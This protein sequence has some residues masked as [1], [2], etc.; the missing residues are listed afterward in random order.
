[1]TYP[2][3]FD[4]PVLFPNSLEQTQYLAPFQRI[5]IRGKGNYTVIGFSKKGV[6]VLGDNAKMFEH[7]NF[8]TFTNFNSPDLHDNFVNPLLEELLLKY[9]SIKRFKEDIFDEK[10]FLCYFPPY[11]LPYLKNDEDNSTVNYLKK[12][13]ELAAI[14]FNP[15]PS[16]IELFTW[17]EKLYFDDK[18]TTNPANLP[19]IEKLY[20]NIR[21]LD[22][23]LYQ[24]A[25]LRRLQISFAKQTDLSFADYEQL[26]V[27]KNKIFSSL[28][29]K[30]KEHEGNLINPELYST[31][32]DSETLNNSNKHALAS[33]LW[34]RRAQEADSSLINNVIDY[35]VTSYYVAEP[36][37]V[38]DYFDQISKYLPADS[39][40]L[41]QLIVIEN[42]AINIAERWFQAN[43][44]EQA[45]KWYTH[46]IANKQDLINNGA[47]ISL[48]TIAKHDAYLNPAN[49]KRINQIRAFLL[50]NYL[51]EG[52]NF[53][54]I[55]KMF[56]SIKP[57]LLEGKGKEQFKTNEK[58]YYQQSIRSI[59]ENIDT[60]IR[61]IDASLA[62]LVDSEKVE[63]K[64]LLSKL[65]AIFS[66]F[67]DFATIPPDISQIKYQELKQ[68]LTKLF[69]DRWHFIKNNFLSYPHNTV[70]L[71]N[72]ACLKLAEQLDPDN[73]YQLMMPTLQAKEDGLGTVLNSLQFG[74][75]VLTDDHTNFIVLDTFLDTVCQ[76]VNKN[77]TNNVYDYLFEDYSLR[78]PSEN[79]FK[80]IAL[81]IPSFSQFKKLAE[82]Q[83]AQDEF[84]A[85][86]A[87]EQLRRGLLKGDASHR[88]RELDAGTDANVA[89]V[90]FLQWYENLKEYQKESLRK[91]NPTRNKTTFKKILKRL[92]KDERDARSN[93][94]QYCVE[95][96][97]RDLEKLI[98]ANTVRLRKIK[99]GHGDSLSNLSEL[100]NL[101][102]QVLSQIKYPSHAAIN[103]KS[104]IFLFEQQNSYKAFTKNRKKKNCFT[105]LES[106]DAYLAGAN[107]G[108]LGY[109][110]DKQNFRFILKVKGTPD[111][112]QAAI[113]YNFY[114]SSYYFEGDERTQF[115]TLEQAIGE[116]A[117]KQ[118]AQDFP[119]LHSL[120]EL[121]TQIT[122]SSHSPEFNN[123]LQ[124]LRYELVKDTAH[125]FSKQKTPDEILHGRVGL[126]THQTTLMLKS[127]HAS[128]SKADKL[129]AITNYHQSINPKATTKSIGKAIAAVAIA[130]VCM[131]LGAAIG[132]LIGV[133]AGCWTG[134]GAAATGLLGL[135]KGAMTGASLGVGIASV[136]TGV[137]VGSLSAFGLFKKNP[138][139]KA[140]RSCMATAE[141]EIENFPVAA[142]G[143]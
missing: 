119:A 103:P 111:I 71:I 64:F 56:L 97:G 59:V 130:G 129:A 77:E 83:M 10:L 133:L 51:S 3:P 37:E 52:Q 106:L 128:N 138:Q 40:K 79:E 93:A 141:K 136:V 107:Q 100:K 81:W 120:R 41:A 43:N 113:C 98:A 104:F 35:L 39:E 140:I 78:Q 33:V 89:T 139:E 80:R 42:D 65:K 94:V 137:S 95:I 109:W 99:T 82:Q 31:L 48:E 13:Q 44:I 20:S 12:A 15:L 123:Y 101:Q 4:L 50:D 57:E 21:T 66:Q 72:Q 86:N 23:A 30:I 134:P 75:F 70:S 28:I 143:A 54:I 58:L 27:V 53:D 85:L 8:Y 46:A 69:S 131:V 105:Q 91:L 124:N 88:G 125:Q 68:E 11:S 60:T 87:F 74:Q 121:N 29:N 112:H 126:V 47:I 61:T 5:V 38:I 76:R 32:L 67:S 84:T 55:S 117:A 63:A 96:T 26:D 132:G 115:T 7:Y 118:Y 90:Q 17:A 135:C 114:Q 49:E 16:D 127:L 24:A 122:H 2:A 62:S 9:F 45:L 36:F 18:I 108:A 1:M 25:S 34:Q 14:E 102:A 73:K 6:Y 19:L 110:F 22:P 116:F 142:P 92:I